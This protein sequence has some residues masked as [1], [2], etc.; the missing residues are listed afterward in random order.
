MHVAKN[1]ASADTSAF[2]AVVVIKRMT[3]IVCNNIYRH[4]QE[5]VWHSHTTQ[6][7]FVSHPNL[8]H[9]PQSSIKQTPDVTFSKSIVGVFGTVFTDLIDVSVC[10]VTHRNCGIHR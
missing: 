4:G 3:G 6:S 1:I 10:S 8:F 7:F 9:H 5:S 2:S